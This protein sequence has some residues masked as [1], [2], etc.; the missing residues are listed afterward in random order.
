LPFASSYA[1]TAAP[2]EVRG[3][4]SEG[5]NMSILALILAI[6]GVGFLAVLWVSI[7]LSMVFLVRGALVRTLG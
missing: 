4:K 2:N 5:G 7:A 3:T 1:E 6:L